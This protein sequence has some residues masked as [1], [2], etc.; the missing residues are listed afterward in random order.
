MV[1]VTVA[2]GGRLALTMTVD[3]SRYVTRRL[4]HPVVCKRGVQ[5]GLGRA[6]A[7]DGMS[8]ELNGQ[9]GS[10]TA[11]REFQEAIQSKTSFDGGPPPGPTWIVGGP[12]LEERCVSQ[13]VFEPGRYLVRVSIGDETV[14]EQPVE[15]SAGKI[16]E[17]HVEVK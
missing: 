4:D 14:A 6:L 9:D 15:I 3:R 1:D 10:R 11:L 8:V 2:T 12:R 17:C 5:T 13:T 16:T 7:I